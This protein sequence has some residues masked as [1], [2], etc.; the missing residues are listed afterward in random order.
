MRITPSAAFKPL[1]EVP[2]GELVYVPHGS[3][4]LLALTARISTNPEP[5]LVCLKVPGMPRPPY[6]TYFPGL[7]SVVTLGSGF[8]VDV[9][10]RAPSEL[11][12]RHYCET[13]GAI[14]LVGSEWHINVYPETGSG[15]YQPMHYVLSSG[16]LIPPPRFDTFAT[17]SK[18]RILL[19]TPNADPASRPSPIFSLDIASSTTA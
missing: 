18:W 6:F 17:F 4:T 1:A 13:G 14:C 12:P 3:E 19:D 11:R 2:P 8:L 15:R 16:Q 7:Y 5:G 10:H 9:D